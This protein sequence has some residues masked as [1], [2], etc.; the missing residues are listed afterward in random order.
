M[1]L[2]A[3]DS[4]DRFVRPNGL[5]L[6]NVEIEYPA[7]SFRGHDHFGRLEC[8]LR[9]EPRLFAA[10]RSKQHNGHIDNPFHNPIDL[11]YASICI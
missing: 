7:G 1:E 2:H 10:C 8:T 3:V 9:I 4:T 6:L 11:M 5:P